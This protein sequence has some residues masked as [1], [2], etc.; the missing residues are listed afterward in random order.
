MADKQKE[1]Q[2]YELIKNQDQLKNK[3]K[4]ILEEVPDSVAIREVA[5]GEIELLN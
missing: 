4:K 2:L 3:L 5:S 1:K